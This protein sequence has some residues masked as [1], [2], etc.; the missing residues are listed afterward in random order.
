MSPRE[1]TR[2]AVSI[3]LLAVSAW[4]SIPLVPVPVTLQT[5]ALALLCTALT[6][7]EA[8]IAVAGYLLLGAVGLPLFS[9]MSGGLS[10]IVGPTGG[11]LW[12]FL[13]GMVAA[14][15]L[16]P[17]VE[18]H[19]GRAVANV[20]GSVTLLLVAYVLGTV[21]LMA[22][23]QMGLPPALLAAVVPF[24]VPDAVKL[25]VGIGVGAAVRRALDALTPTAR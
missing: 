17:A 8:V 22:V 6:G 18:K 16:M 5:L 1:V 20:A 25:A 13:V 7:R 9:G 10:S 3:A 2:C 23:A 19:A 15:L 14:K 4:V 21:Q 24:I 11:Y 12:G